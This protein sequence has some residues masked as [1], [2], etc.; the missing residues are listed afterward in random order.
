MEESFDRSIFS[1]YTNS[2]Y[3]MGEAIENFPLFFVTSLCA[4]YCLCLSLPSPCASLTRSLPD[5]GTGFFFHSHFISC[6][7][8]CRECRECQ[9]LNTVHDGVLMQ[10][11]VTGT[12]PSVLFSLIFCFVFCVRELVCECAGNIISQRVSKVVLFLRFTMG[13]RNISW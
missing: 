8:K 10:V 9:M 7:L 5:V 11:P 3:N 2:S 4:C 1:L 12:L 13:I 6:V